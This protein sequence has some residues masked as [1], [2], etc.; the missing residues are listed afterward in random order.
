MRLPSFKLRFS[1]AGL[2]LVVTALCTVLGW[3]MSCQA[4]LQRLHVATQA[5]D[6]AAAIALFDSAGRDR[7][8]A[9]R[10]IRARLCRASCPSAGGDVGGSA[11]THSGALDTQGI[12][13]FHLDRFVRRG[14]PAVGIGERSPRIA[15]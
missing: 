15:K 10:E 7:F 5:N 12:G 11:S 8:L 4:T 2:L 13:R 9:G 1:L 3:R 6:F 14:R